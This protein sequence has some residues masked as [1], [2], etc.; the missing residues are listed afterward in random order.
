MEKTM[1][2]FGEMSVAEIEAFIKDVVKPELKER[3]AIEKAELMESVKNQ[4]HE[5]DFVI[6]NLKG[7][8]ISGTVVALREKTFSLLTEDILNAKGEP[9]RVSRGYDFVVEIG[10]K[11]EED[12][13]ASA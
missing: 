2:I 13:E 7:S 4:L 1:E 10:E 12:F 5:G 9:S 3:K 6:V 8:E 11:V